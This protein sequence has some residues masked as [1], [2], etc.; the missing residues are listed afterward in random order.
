M[1]LPRFSIAGIMALTALIALD[2]LATR[3]VWDVGDI[4]F[5]MLYFVALPW[6]NVLLIGVTVLRGRRRRGEPA[7]FFIGFEAVGWAV[8]LLSVILIFAFPSVCEAVINGLNALLRPLMNVMP[9]VGFV[10][11]IAACMAILSLPQL[12]A[13]V[14]AGLLHRRYRV[15]VERREPVGVGP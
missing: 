11:G 8:L 7:A 15:R 14:A 13:A 3:A 4:R 10:A 12:I 5:I 6:L 2:C 9:P 1:R